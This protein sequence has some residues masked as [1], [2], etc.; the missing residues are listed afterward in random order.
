MCDAFMPAPPSNA[1]VRA[2]VSGLIAEQVNIQ[3]WCG[4]STMKKK[5]GGERIEAASISV[6]AVADGGVALHAD[7]TDTAVVARRVALQSVG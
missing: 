7:P 5:W 2:S 6:E 4:L 1:N 3:T